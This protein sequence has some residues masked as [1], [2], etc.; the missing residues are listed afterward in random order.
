MVADLSLCQLAEPKIMAAP[1]R[2]YQELRESNPIYWDPFLHAWIVTRYADIVTVLGRFSADRTVPPE[3]LDQLGL[4]RLKPIFEVMSRQMLFRDPPAHTRLRSLCSTAFSP[5]RVAVLRQHIQDI[6]DGL[7]DKFHSRGTADIIGDLAS[8]MPGIV[9]AEILGVPVQHHEKLKQWSI[10]FAEIIGNFQHQS[11]RVSR[12]VA[13]VHEMTEYFRAAVRAQDTDPHEGL[14][15]SLVEAQVGGARLTEDEIIANCV[16]TMI[17]GQETTTNLI[18]S[19]LLTLLQHPSQMQLLLDD[20]SLI[21]MA[22][23]ELLRY[24]SPIQYTARVAREEF[25]LGGK[26]IRPGQ[27]VVTVL[28]AGNRD[29]ERFADPDVLDLKRGDKGHLAFGWAAHFCFGAHLARLEGPIAFGSILRRLKNLRLASNDFTWRDNFG[30]R[31]LHELHVHF[32]RHESEQCP[33]GC[34]A[35]GVTGL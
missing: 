21:P 6:V 27:V 28:A 19:G 15:H 14:I 29:P 9:T 10:D 34:S 35:Q 2:F 13:S 22:I 7:I 4:G 3:K 20:P 11:D 12:V 8:P 17:G 31:G 30:L 26:F 23:E 25:L 1:H 5:A 18:G 33:S 32:D 24:E 16:I